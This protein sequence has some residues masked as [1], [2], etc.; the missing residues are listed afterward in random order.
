VAGHFTDSIVSLGTMYGRGS[1]LHLRTNPRVVNGAGQRVP[2]ISAPVAILVDDFSASATEFFS[3]GMQALGR[4]RI[5]GVPTAGQSLPA[6]MF[7]L[8]SGDVLMHPIADHEDTNGRRVEGTGVTPD[9]HTPLTRTDLRAGRDA[10][11]D[12]ARDW[13]ARS[14]R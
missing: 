11:L 12:A 2:V 3:A 4:A 5:F 9:T 6:A 8:P 14:I 7:R 13:L 1:T 10:A